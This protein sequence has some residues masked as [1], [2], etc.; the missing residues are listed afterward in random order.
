MHTSS[1]I[2]QISTCE[3]SRATRQCSR[4]SKASIRS[5]V[6][7]HMLNGFALA[8]VVFSAASTC[9][10]FCET[11]AMV[12]SVFA[13]EDE[14]QRTKHFLSHSCHQIP[15]RSFTV[16]GRGFPV[17]ARCLGI[18]FGALV[19]LV[20]GIIVR[21]RNRRIMCCLV[22]LAFL[23]IFLKPFGIDTPNTWR[24]VAGLALGYVAGY[25]VATLCICCI[26]LL[27][28]SPRQWGYSQPSRKWQ[29][30]TT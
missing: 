22:L 5:A 18:R 7:F 23:D 30:L 15:S 28:H 17:C 2:S 24:L 12:K 8:L 20:F 26:R 11:G 6:A 1:E 27:W 3:P 10:L 13:T 21:R 19:G 4:G 16:N 29:R 25:A 9:Y 14:Y